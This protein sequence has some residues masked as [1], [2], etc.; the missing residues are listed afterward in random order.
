MST[1]IDPAAAAAF[2]VWGSTM[3]RYFSAAGTVLLHYDWLLTLDDEVCLILSSLYYPTACLQMRL[4]WS[5]ALSWPT[6][7]YYANRYV[8]IILMSYSNYG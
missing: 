5:G 6:A 1:T 3:K 8:T 4:V 7:L 2:E